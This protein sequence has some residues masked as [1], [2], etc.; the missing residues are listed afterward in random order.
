MFHVSRFKI[1]IVNHEQF[2][3]HDSKKKTI[4][5]T[6]IFPWPPPGSP[7]PKDNPR[8]NS[9]H[10]ANRI[11]YTATVTIIGL[12][13]FNFATPNSE[14]NHINHAKFLSWRPLGSSYTYIAY[15]ATFTIIGLWH[16]NFVIP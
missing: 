10:V 12:W 1:R 14:K 2:M 16:F 13:N 11:A 9:G 4:L 6:A 8:G 5:P 7:T 3:I 15:T